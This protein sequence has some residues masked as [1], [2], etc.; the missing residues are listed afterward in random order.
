MLLLELGFGGAPE[1]DR[2][3]RAVVIVVLEI[4][5]IALQAGT[6]TESD[7]YVRN[8]SGCRMATRSRARRASSGCG[9][10]SA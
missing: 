10:G 9:H 2:A 3:R 1:G 6:Q 8:E 4:V 7:T 5:R